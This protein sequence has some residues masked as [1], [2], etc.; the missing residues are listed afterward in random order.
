VSIEANKALVRRVF[1][2][3]F[4]QRK[5][6]VLDEVFSPTFVDASTPEQEPGPEGVKGY[7]T[8]IHT[9]FPDMQVSI[10]DLIA[11]GDK[12]VVR[13]IWHGTHTGQYEDIAP[14]G[15][16]VT[17]TMIHIFRVEGGSIQEEWVKGESLEQQLM[18]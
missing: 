13:T 11:E 16:Q 18:Q 7:F 9:G 1:D 14:T 3:A 17:R 12:V 8:T 6:A 4:S 10:G 15:K 2:E 5:L